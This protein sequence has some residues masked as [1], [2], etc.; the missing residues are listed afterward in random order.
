MC[1]GYVCEDHVT[2]RAGSD[3]CCEGCAEYFFRKDFDEEEE[4]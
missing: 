1:H 4:D 3:F 2:E